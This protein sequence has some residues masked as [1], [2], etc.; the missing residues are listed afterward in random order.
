MKH[1]DNNGG[2]YA[3]DLTVKKDFLIFKMLIKGKINQ[4]G[5]I[6]MQNFCP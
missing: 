1:R 2:K 5:Y 4:L 6:M 3:Y